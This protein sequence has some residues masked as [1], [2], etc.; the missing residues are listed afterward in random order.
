MNEDETHSG[1]SV[2]G[3]VFKS[4]SNDADGDVGGETYFWF[5]QTDDLIHARYHGGSVRLGHLVGHHLGDTLDFRYTHVTVDGDTATGH[6]VDRIERL[7]DGRLRLH[8]EWEWDSK[9]GSGS[10][11]LEE[12]PEQQIPPIEG[13]L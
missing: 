5:E 7:D 13:P 1:L 4:V 8:E 3:R 2:D 10:S 6:S 9:P 12:V 11:V